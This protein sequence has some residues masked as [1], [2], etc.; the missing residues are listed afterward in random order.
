ME[1]FRTHQYWRR[2]NPNRTSLNGVAKPRNPNRPK[3]HP[4]RVAGTR[5]RRS[6]R[7]HHRIILLVVGSRYCW[8]WL[9]RS[10]RSSRPVPTT[11]VHGLFRWHYTRLKLLIQAESSE[12]VRFV[13]RVEPYRRD[14]SECK[15]WPCEHSNYPNPRQYKRENRLEFPFW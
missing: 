8:Q 15:T 4:H 14:Y 3:P 1:W 12:R 10:C 5:R 11:R 13:L 2:L 7:Q 6:K 9:G